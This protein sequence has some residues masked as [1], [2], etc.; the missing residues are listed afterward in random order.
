MLRAASGPL[1]PLAV[2]PLENSLRVAAGGTAYEQG[3][4]ERYI[5]PLIYPAELTRELQ[6]VLGGVLVG[7]NLAVYGLVLYRRRRS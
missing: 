5:V 1:L 4:V 6:F 3:F 7:I 2:T